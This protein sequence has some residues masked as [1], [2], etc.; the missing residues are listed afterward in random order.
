MAF[1]DWNKHPDGKVEVYPLVAYETLVPH[2][3]M[4]GLK[5]HY[6]ESPDDFLAGKSSSIPL[7]LTPNLA[8]QL[9]RALIKAADKAE[10]GS[11][12]EKPQ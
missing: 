2:G 3:V 4:C 9:A 6:L 1:E 8:R 10:H 12:R 7:I 5:L 11:A